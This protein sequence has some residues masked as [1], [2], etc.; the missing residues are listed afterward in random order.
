VTH[1]QLIL[2][3]GGSRSGKSAFALDAARRLGPRRLFVATA[4]AGDEEMGERIRLHRQTRGPDFHTM[5]EPLQIAELL[6]RQLPYD[7]AVL[8]CL[9]LWLSNLLLA[10]N[11]LDAVLRRVDDLVEVLRQRRIHTVIVTNE[12]GLGL[13]PETALGRIFRDAAGSAHQR[14]ASIADQVYVGLLGVMLRLKPAPIGGI[15]L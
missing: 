8:D 5:E 4:E 1:P 14:L 9:T 11:D 10:G 2:I 3:G 7:V 15:D 6:R 12:V 13:V